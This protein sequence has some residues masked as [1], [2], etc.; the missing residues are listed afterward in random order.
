[1]SLKTSVER[2][3]ISYL[4]VTTVVF[5]SVRRNYSHK[6]NFL[7]PVSVFGIVTILSRSCHDAN[8]TNCVPEIWIAVAVTVRD[9]SLSG[10]EIMAGPASLLT[11][12]QPAPA[13][14]Q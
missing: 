2:S 12:P 7:D 5:A 3:S 14:A 10:V 11:P 1:M 13:G 9:G 8:V 6:C 4:T